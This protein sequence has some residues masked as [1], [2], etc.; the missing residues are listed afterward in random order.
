MNCTTFFAFTFYPMSFFLFF[1]LFFI[2]WREGRENGRGKIKILF[3]EIEKDTTP[4]FSVMLHA[5]R[6]K[7]TSMT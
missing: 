3:K 2:F 5:R 6:K 7:N 1:F 4:L